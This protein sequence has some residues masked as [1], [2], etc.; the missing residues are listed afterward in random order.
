[1]SDASNPSPPVSAAGSH[2]GARLGRWF[3][4]VWLA[5]AVLA[6]LL[7]W[8]TVA[9]QSGARAV[10]A[11]DGPWSRAQGRASL[12]LERYGHTRA[13]ADWQAYRQAVEPLLALQRAREDATGSAPDLARAHAALT[14]LGS[15]DA[16]AKALTRLYRWSRRLPPLAGPAALI[17]ERDRELTAFAAAAEALHRA[18]Q[19]GADAAAVAPLRSQVREVDVRLA[20]L[21]ARWAATLGAQLRDMA[22]ALALA[23][24]VVALG[25]GTLGFVAVR[26]RT[27]GD[28][29]ATRA[30]A[31]S[32]T[33][34][35]SL[36]E[37]TSDA[38]LIV[39][40][41]H[42]IRFANPAAH[43]LS[44]HPPG[45]LVG[46]SLTTLQPERL[47][48][49]HQTAM[50]RHLDT[51]ERRLDW[52][53][54]EIALLHR[55]GRELPVEIRFARFD[56]DGQVHFVGFLRDITARKR[57]EQAIQEA[58]ARLEQRVAERTQELSQANQRLL[59]V[60][61]LKS[62]F[63]ATMSHELRTPLNSIL[64]F[65]ELLRQGGAGPVN[66]EQR[67]QLDFVHG[68]GE[69]LLALIS[70]LLDL[71]RIESGRMEVAHEAFDFAELAD[72]VVSQLSQAADR[73]SIRLSLQ[74]A[75]PMPWAG[76]RR[77]VYQVLLNLA[78]N[79]LKF[80]ERGEVTIVADASP[81]ALSFEVRDTGIGIAPEQLPKLF[82][83][84]HQIDSGL[85]RVHEGT[86]LG[87]YL[88]RKLLELMGGRIEVQS[89]PAQGSRFRVVL[90][91][92]GAPQ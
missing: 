16:D 32:E 76:D 68:S 37:T 53:G 28:V 72:Q 91:R 40:A 59:E 63:L 35:R 77:K 33:L 90:P 79:A 34:F 27:R 38:V 67:R 83:A 21:Q 50:R 61:R 55:D 18:L 39:G 7:A 48:A 51:G 78:G 87:L 57:A 62:E 46:A 89:A 75:R 19:A 65:A 14:A 44:G 12:A 41:D 66:E 92:S 73:K 4:S 82:Q 47:R 8:A 58:Q 45:T 80:T 29:A 52:G 85:G 56:L 24:V 84:F 69:H 54:T 15:P 5:G 70:D 43:V 9:L 26:A 36:W 42:L 88:T 81:E 20:S 60:D 31:R 13:A 86:G 71:S 3:A 30:L 1:M 64:G 22:Q 11:T 2:H 10:I 23:L 49:A 25:L 74:A 6:A 17:A